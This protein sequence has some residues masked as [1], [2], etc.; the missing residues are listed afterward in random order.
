MILVRSGG[1][2][3]VGIALMVAGV[4]LLVVRP[5]IDDTTGRALE[6][7]DRVLDETGTQPEHGNHVS[8]AAFAALVGQ[9]KQKLGTD[10]EL[11]DLT[12]SANGGNVK[13][14]TGDGAAGYKWGPDHD[15]LEAVKV[16]LVG[17]G[18]LAENVFPITKLHPA[19]GA[20]LT[21]AAD[22]DI[23]TMML[24]INP[25]T[26]KVRWTVTGEREG[27]PAVH[28]QRVG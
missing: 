11:L 15:G 14:R 9:I 7:A 26:G 19:A 6:T 27:R 28:V 20:K 24:A 16:K 23:Q 1:I 2:A 4:F 17:P 12:V 10:A 25:A 5:A 18:T 13:Y 3:G 21:A 22:F 8:P